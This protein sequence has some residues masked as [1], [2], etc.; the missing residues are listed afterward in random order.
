MYGDGKASGT[1]DGPSLSPDSILKH[2]NSGQDAPGTNSDCT[3]FSD[4]RQSFRVFL[5]FS[6]ANTEG[7]FG[8]DAVAI[9]LEPENAWGL[10]AI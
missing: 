2:T 8:V 5:F 1:G 4:K 9:D 6:R 10:D 3:V 7:G